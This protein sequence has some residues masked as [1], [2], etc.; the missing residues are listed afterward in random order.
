MRLADTRLIHR[1]ALFA[2]LILFSAVAFSCTTLETVA[3]EEEMPQDELT[4]D[5][6][7]EED[8]EAL[9]EFLL[10]STMEWDAFAS[11]PNHPAHQSHPA[12]IDVAAEM[13]KYRE[14]LI[15]AE[16]DKEFWF[17]LWKIS[18]VRLD[19]HLRVTEIDEGLDLPEHLSRRV[20]APIRFKVDYSDLDNR[21]F[22]IG[23]LGAEIDQL[24][25]GPAPE[26]GDRLTAVNGRQVN[27]YVE[28][29]RPY[30]RYSTENP[31]WWNLASEITRT[32]DYIPHSKFYD[33]ELEILN[34]ELERPDGSRYEVN[35]PYMEPDEIEW[36][37]HRERYYPGFVKIEEIEENNTFDLFLPEER[38]YPVVLLQWHRFDRDL[39]E[40]MDALMEYAVEHDLLGHH[41]IVDATRSGGGSRGSYAVRRLQ[42]EPHRGT[43]GN[44]KV[45]E[46]MERWVEERIERFR[47]GDV[48][49]AT[50]DDGTWQRE[51][52]E[53]DVRDAIREGRY[54][55]NDVPF[56][57]AHAPKWSDGIIEPAETHFSGGMTVW[58]NP[59]GG[60]HLDQFAAQIVDNDLAHLMGMPTG[61]FSNTWQTTE[62]LRFPTTGKPIVEYQ[63]SLGHSI[64][65]NKE[66]LQYN[67]AQPHEY[68]PVTREN[69]FN[70]HEM[71]LERTFQR[72]GLA[73]EE[74]EISDWR[75]MTEDERKVSEM[76]EAVDEWTQLQAPESFEARFET[77]QGDFDI[78]AVREW[79]P[80][81][82]DRLYQLIRS[83]FYSDI[84]IFRVVP[85]FVVQF[86]LHD[87]NRLNEKWEEYL[88]EDE[89]VTQSNRK[90]KIAFARSGPD[91]RSTQIFVN[92]EDN[93][94]RLDTLDYMDVRGFPVIAEVVSG[95]DVVEA[96][97]DGY[98]NEPSG[99]Q[100]TIR[101]EGNR[102]LKEEFP[103]IDYIKRAY[104]LKEE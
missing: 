40:A 71:M 90:G 99:L 7:T 100:D 26:L 96:F 82:V 9:F 97:Y 61:G 98:G 43:F 15:A 84:G 80:Q 92:L 93:S 64:R 38:G 23:D 35:V 21:F 32:R 1:T 24:V 41:V 28:A 63:W 77:T 104:L 2:T 52:L 3:E 81:G 49:P 72:I 48:S 36:Q 74:T 33:D 55:T 76:I 29:I 31:F 101:A 58:L 62:V 25:D 94:P 50:E 45:S 11:L 89:P 13:E 57:G 19:R 70:Y 47:T 17:A 59:A 46:A 54:Y 8:R 18:N 6:G 10:E 69:Y 16:T 95:M 34:L 37:G 78:R 51:W 60:S 53:E 14:E 73:E 86:G 56:K 102:F 22:F 87:D 83:G 30:Q 44:L 85:G 65:P 20:E 12:G 66:I 42:P 4:F 75:K 103:K 91:S 67:P 88:V 39:P 68:I 5:S 27:E 79:S